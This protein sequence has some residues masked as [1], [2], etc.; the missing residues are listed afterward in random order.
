MNRVLLQYWLPERIVGYFFR[1]RR[2]RVNVD[3]LFCGEVAHRGDVS[4]GEFIAA[5]AFAANGWWWV[6]V[7]SLGLGTGLAALFSTSVPSSST[8][9][10]LPLAVYGVGAAALAQYP[11]LVYRT[12]RVRR[13]GTEQEPVPERL[14]PKP[15]DFWMASFFGIAG[16]VIVVVGR[17]GSTGSAFPATAP[18]S[19]HDSAS[20]RAIVAVTATLAIIAGLAVARSAVRRRPPN[21]RR[22]SWREVASTPGTREGLLVCGLV[23]LVAGGI[24][25]GLLPL[26]K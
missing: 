4:V 6:A 1:G 7:F 18:G 22:M 24:G 20:I 9:W 21:W 12:G 3:R 25:L 5:S 26:L 23:L 8:A 16:T 10:G 13:A 19:G 17:S 15:R 11:F 2:T 14:M